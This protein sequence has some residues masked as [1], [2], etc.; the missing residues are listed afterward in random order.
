[1]K[2]IGKSDEIIRLFKDVLKTNKYKDLV[3]TDDLEVLSLALKYK[4]EIPYFLMTS[5]LSYK[6][7][8]KEL[9]HELINHADQAF[10]ISLSTSNLLQTKDNHA[11]IFGMIKIPTYQAKD[12]GEFIFVLDRL[13]IPGNIGT[14]YRTLDACGATGVILVDPITKLNSVKLLAAARGTNLIVPTVSLSYQE[15]IRYLSKEEYTLYLGEPELGLDYQTYDYK[16]KIAIVVGNERF[17]IQQDCYTHSHQKVF[18]PMQGNNH[19]LNVSV[20]ASI[21]AYEAAMKRKSFNKK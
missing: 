19:S 4:L 8:T 10:E 20:A 15:A 2:K 7:S 6:E 9:I 21:L 1:M 12:L 3:A 11:G 13:E 17:G 14:I 18:I 16:G 5:D